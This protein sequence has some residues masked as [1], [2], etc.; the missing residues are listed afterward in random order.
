MARTSSSL[1]HTLFCTVV[2]AI[3]IKCC[4]FSKSKGQGSI[5]D[6]KLCCGSQQDPLTHLKKGQWHS[7]VWPETAQDGL[8]P[9]FYWQRFWFSYTFQHSRLWWLYQVGHICLWLRKKRARHLIMLEKLVHGSLRPSLYLLF[10]PPLTAPPGCH[11]ERAHTFS[12]YHW[13]FWVH[14][15]FG[16]G[17][18]GGCAGWF[19]CRYLWSV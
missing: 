19:L 10:T 9:L 6:L 18:M 5:P 1:L 17:R 13:G 16:G 7:S 11:W 12:Q 15:C 8:F 14:M 2:S 3:S 4:N